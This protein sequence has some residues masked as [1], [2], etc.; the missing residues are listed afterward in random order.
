MLADP[1]VMARSCIPAR[2]DLQVVAEGRRLRLLPDG[3]APFRVMMDGTLGL[4]GNFTAKRLTTN[5]VG[6][7]RHALELAALVEGSGGLLA[8]CL[9]A[10][11]AAARTAALFRALDGETDDIP[12]WSREMGGRTPLSA[13][14]V[15]AL[16]PVLRPFLSF[17]A[18]VLP[19]SLD[20]ETALA[21]SKWLERTWNLIG[22]AET[23]MAAGGD[24]RLELD[25]H[26]GLNH[27]GCS[28]RPR[29]WAV[30]FSSST[31][32]SV[33]ERGFAGAE[34]ARLRLQRALLHDE[35][36]K[37]LAAMA[38]EIRSFLARHFDLPNGEHVI[39]APSG[40]DCELAALVLSERNP[41]HRPV[42]NILIAPE[43][44]GSGVPLAA[45][46][47][48]FASD[49]ARVPH[50]ERG[51]II[52]GFCKAGAV[53]VEVVPLRCSSGE[54]VPAAELVQRCRNLVQTAARHGRHVLLH[55][56]DLS[57]TG[58]LAPDERE[59]SAL[60]EESGAALDVV[61]DACQARLM[62]ER[63]G[64]W[65]RAGRAVMVTGSKFVTGPPFCGALLLPEA[66][67]ARLE[68][69]DDLPAG[70]K[71]YAG[72]G[73]W[74][75]CAATREL[76]AV[77]NHGLILRWQAAIAEMKALEAVPT[78]EI[79]RR[80]DV[81]LGAVRAAMEQANDIRL[82][83]TPSPIRPHLAQEW[84]DRST[85]L[86]FLVRAVDGVE[87]DATFRPMNLEDARRLYRWLN[88]DLR[89]AFS[90]NETAY[91][92]PNA[93]LLCHV[94]QPVAVP[95]AELAGEMAG[96]LRIS[97]GA[98][99]VSGEPSHEGLDTDVRLAREIG[100]ARRI[101]AKVALIRR[102]WA[103]IARHDPQPTYAPVMCDE[104]DMTGWTGKR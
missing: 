7:L 36:Q 41:A 15:A 13:S 59:L 54:E 30:T 91:H 22:P 43:E 51:A 77:S 61:V 104:D 23:L 100:D 93:G 32:S 6:I 101:L 38:R 10:S 99:L 31:A 40:T 64:G 52:P 42:T 8:P 103:R 21:V 56:L 12:D 89:P 1:P 37:T 84:D 80:L 63:V 90:P 62:P 35:G 16:W 85:I 28:H 47:R 3:E 48:H 81:F 26:T 20:R 14:R 60:A 46:G 19:V 5:Q 66:W 27:Y 33:S 39:L 72:Q 34:Q 70:L 73:E 67:R 69:A 44:T 45:A 18:G 82:L 17:P 78:P 76:S 24:A 95:S 57:K 79:G 98:R 86:C 97:A 25:P 87:D 53:E 88:A 83:T 55:Q 50:V 96:A 11:F 75:A 49:T 68:A 58:L 92:D 65:V 94:G 9:R 102:H 4:S 2:P 74:P 29:P 71:D